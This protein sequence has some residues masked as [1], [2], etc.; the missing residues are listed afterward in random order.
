M[1]ELSE[2]IEQVYNKALGIVE[3]LQGKCAGLPVLSK[4]STVN[5]SLLLTVLAGSCLALVVLMMILIPILVH[6]AKIKR[7]KKK[8]KT[9]FGIND[10]QGFKVSKMGNSRDKYFRFDNCNYLQLNLPYWKKPQGEDPD[11]KTRRGPIV[12]PQSILWL[13]AGKNTYVMRTKDPLDMLFLVHFLRD[14]GVVIP[15][16]QQEIEKREQTREKRHNAEE[17]IR[18]VYDAMDGNEARFVDLCRERLSSKGYN[19]LMVE[20]ALGIDFFANE[21]STSYAV[22]CFL[23]PRDTLTGMEALKTF[24]QLV[25]N[26]YSHSCMFITTGK[27]TYAAAQFAGSNGVKIICNDDLVALLDKTPAPVPGQEYKSWELTPDDLTLLVQEGIS[28][29]K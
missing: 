2:F 1:Q 9:F 14:N 27:V 5:S 19:V 16:C 11:K 24:Y 15:P 17:I 13:S 21:K 6:R 4:L 18:N 29:R 20:N 8:L 28:L 3:G 26:T 22:K 12:R 23:T 25:K 7:C 10:F